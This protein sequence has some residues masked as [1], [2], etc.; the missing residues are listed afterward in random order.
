MIGIA[1][2]LIDVLIGYATKRS[3][4][5]SVQALEEIKAK[6]ETDRQKA[7]IIRAQLGHW[8]AW[9]PRFLVE[10]AATLYFG[11]IV[12]DSIW[13]LDGTVAALP[14]NEAA[15]MA[16]IFAGMFITASFRK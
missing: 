1:L 15:L 3:D 6:V 14:T 16:T 13:N 11:S 10:M 5:K 8:I 7:E 2:K 4:Q 9:L 12:I